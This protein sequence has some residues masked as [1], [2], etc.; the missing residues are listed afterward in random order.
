MSYWTDEMNSQE[1]RLEALSP[2]ARLKVAFR[3]LAWTVRTL[4][5]PI[6][7]PDVAA[8]VTD[9]L[10]RIESAVQRGLAIPD[11]VDAVAER[12]N[13]LLD[14]AWEPGATNFLTGT[15]LC[16]SRR[17]PELPAGTI[18]DQLLDLYEG[19][20]IRASDEAITPEVE[21]ATPRA[22][23]VIEFQKRL[24]DEVSRGA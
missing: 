15:L 2:Q 1:A 24:I 23:E 6:E 22:V 3:A 17:R 12:Y 16:F 11:G 19:A 10:A 8:F 14:E 20:L 9:G 13:E 5:S 21:R 4:E 18:M 7:D